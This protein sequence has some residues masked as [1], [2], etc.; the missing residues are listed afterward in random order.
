MSAVLRD[1]A[2]WL[3]QARSMTPDALANEQFGSALLGLDAL[4]GGKFASQLIGQGQAMR[5]ARGKASN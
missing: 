5:A 4:G 2:G 3:S 1:N